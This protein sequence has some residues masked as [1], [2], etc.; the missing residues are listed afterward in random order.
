MIIT[1][2][3]PLHMCNVVRSVLTV[4][5]EQEM[6]L[7]QCHTM[8]NCDFLADCIKMMQL[9]PQKYKVKI[10][11]LSLTLE[12]VTRAKKSLCLDKTNGMNTVVRVAVTE[13]IGN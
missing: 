8:N 1:N 9:K 11:R 3:E 10:N 13:Y 6:V 2:A 7:Y 4:S 5:E 12:S